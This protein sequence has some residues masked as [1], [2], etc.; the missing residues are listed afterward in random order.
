MLGSAGR[1]CADEVGALRQSL[2]EAERVRARVDCAVSEGGG[3]GAKRGR[4]GVS[5]WSWK[6]T[7]L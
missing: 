6:P 7:G 1:C 2:A 4:V 3:R 5:A